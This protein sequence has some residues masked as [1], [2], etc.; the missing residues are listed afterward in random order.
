MNVLDIT[1][2]PTSAMSWR[3]TSDQELIAVLQQQA[4][5]L[6]R[7][8]ERRITLER[9]LAERDRE[10]SD[11][12]EN[13]LEGL[14]KA[15]PD[16][17]VFWINRAG[18][19]LLGGAEAQCIGRSIEDFHV[20]PRDARQS[21]RRLLAGETLRDYPTVLRCA[22]G[23]IRHVRV[24]ANSHWDA[25]KLI[26]SRWFVRDVT[27]E[28][29]AAGSRSRELER[30]EEALLEADRRKDEFLA[31]LAHE[32]RNPLAP[33]RYAVAMARKEGRDETERL[34][35]QAIIER[36]V[37]HMSRLLDDLL[38]VSR[39]TRGKLI[40]RPAPVDLAAAIAAAQEAARP[41]MEERRHT[42]VVKLPQEPVRLASDPVR[43]AQ[44]LANLLINAAKYTDSGGRI[45]L[46]ASRAG[47]ALVVVVRDNGIGISA[48]MMPR[49]FTLF[50]QASP[51]L[52]RSEGGL[53]IG[54][55]LVRGLVE[56]HGGS[57]SAH[58]AG[59]GK[60]S[61]FVVRLP[62]GEID[63]ASDGGRDF[64]DSAR[65]G[66]AGRAAC[67]TAKA[68]RLLVADDNRDSAATCAAL[69]EASGH[70]VSVAHT[71][72]EAFDLACRLQPDALLLDIGM[73]ELNGY[74]LA[75]RIRA[76]AWGRRAMLIAITGW[77][78]DEDKRRALA[79]G[80]D[81]H[82]TK[83]FD[84]SGLEAL[85]QLAPGRPG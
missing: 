51:A 15:G 63:A 23:S 44:V 22:D 81:E 76:T 1:Q 8:V 7:E 50:A 4:C 58:S 61:E 25:G 10:L 77:G 45:E 74:Q 19:E 40:L 65:A 83:P 41:L 84:P 75:Q 85:L 21:L 52:E 6:E 32:L 67:S 48:E 39:I 80:F 37:K 42:L 69:L 36:Q 3:D 20:D 66:R 34:Q 71:G 13:A 62:I 14:L 57:V 55:A 79:A 73:P 27:P 5:A 78:Q 33:I 16:G 31:V 64:G 46:E 9:T 24:T 38:D 17:T 47:G 28:R 18:L 29:L 60:G 30:A 49:V 53:G 35:A 56:L 11:F 68:L 2:R 82:L 54:L 72:R 43:L 59:I 70:Q 12:L 26:H